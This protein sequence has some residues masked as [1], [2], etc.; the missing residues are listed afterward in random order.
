VYVPVAAVNSGFT[1]PVKLIRLSIWLSWRFKE[2]PM[3][4]PDID[5]AL[6]QSAALPVKVI[7]P[8]I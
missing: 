3:T 2:V 8:V 5:A 6:P 1:V 4:V 7:W